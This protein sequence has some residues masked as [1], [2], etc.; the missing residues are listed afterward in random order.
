MIIVGNGPS[1]L[2]KK[3][4]TKIDSF[5]SIVRFNDYK[6]KGFEPFTG[7]KTTHWWNTVSF[8][9]PHHPLLS[10]DYTEVCLHSWQFSPQKDKLWQRFS[11]IISA[12]KIFKSQE[13]WIFE[14]QQFGGTK[15][16]GFSTGLLAIWYYLKSRESVFITGFD[17]WE[18][19]ERHHFGDNAIRG[20]LHQPE[21]EKKIID[22]LSKSGQLNWLV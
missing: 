2:D 19:R 12:K 20:S 6:I 7:E 17:W 8:V 3:L 5:K 14:L 9:Q 15:Y 4:G 22:K 21:E 1:I 11:P 13:Q 16:Y 18:N 10:K